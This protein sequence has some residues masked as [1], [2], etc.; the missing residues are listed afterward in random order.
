MAKRKFS[1]ERL[2]KL[3]RNIFL[4]ISLLGLIASALTF[5]I[6]KSSQSK[7]NK[8]DSAVVFP[9]HYDKLTFSNLD[10]FLNYVE[11]DH[12]RRYITE[13]DS[14]WKLL[15]TKE[16][17]EKEEILRKASQEIEKSR[18]ALRQIIKLPNGYN[19]ALQLK[20]YRR[21]LN[22]DIVISM[23]LSRGLLFSAI[24]LQII[25]WGMVWLYSYLFPLAEIN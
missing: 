12:A 3:T 13:D 16:Q 24:I 14:R 18:E 22:D 8:I 1:I 19:N 5:Y 21:T 17:R 10:D 6:S 9:A 4:L 11:P 23:N 7:L 2:Y 25:F 15:Q 20:N